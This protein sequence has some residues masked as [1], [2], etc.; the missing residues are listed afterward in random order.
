VKKIALKVAIA[1]AI[2]AL[3]MVVL[4]PIWTDPVSAGEDDLGYYYPLRKMVGQE[5]AAGRLPLENP[6]EATGGVL[7]S[8]PQSAVMYPPT[9]LFAFMQPKLAYSLSIFLGFALA[10]GG[11]WLYMRKLGLRLPAA[12]VGTLAFMFCGFLIGHRVHLSVLH[13]AGWL[14]WGLWCIDSLRDK[15]R[16]A[17][18]AMPA[19]ALMALTAGH[20]PTLI[21]VGIIWTAYL[22]LRARPFWRSVGIAA[23]AVA[24]AAVIALPQ[25]YA[26][27]H[28]L[29]QTT[30]ARVGYMMAGE[31]SFLPT[32][33]VMAFFP[34]IYGSRT[35][36]LYPQQWWGPWH[37][38]EMLG[39]VG[40]ATLALA[41]AGASMGRILRR[42]GGEVKESPPIEAGLD[43]PKIVRAWFWVAVGAFVFMLGYYLPTYKLVHMLPVLG[44]MRCPARMVLAVDLALAAMAAAAVHMLLER[45]DDKRLRAAA[46]RWIVVILPVTMFAVAAVSLAGS[47]VLTKHF[48]GMLP[49]AGGSENV[50]NAITPSSPAVAI[51]LV[52]LCLTIGVVGFWWLRRPRRRAWGLAALL[53]VD[54]VMVARFVDIPAASHVQQD[55]DSSPAAAWLAQHDPPTFDEQGRPSYRVWGLSSDYCNRP[56]ELMLAKTCN[57][58][59]FATISNYGPFQNPLHQR[60]FG[61]RIFGYGSDRERLLRENYL[62]TL[63]DVKYV[64][65]AVNE[66]AQP[67]RGRELRREVP[68]ALWQMRLPGEHATGDAPPA[69]KRD[70][71]REDPD[72][73]PPMLLQSRLP[74]RAAV[75]ALPKLTRGGV[76]LEA[77]SSA[78]A[79][80][81]LYLRAAG[82]EHLVV[83]AETITPQ[84]RR[85]EVPVPETVDLSEI[86][87]RS[88]TPI[89]VRLLAETLHRPRPVVL[90]GGAL[91]GE[92]VY[93]PVA[94]LGALK[95]G[96]EDVV[97]YR[98][99]LFGLKPEYLKQGVPVAGG[100]P[101]SADSEARGMGPANGEPAPGA[102]MTQAEM[103]EIWKFEPHR[104]LE[105]RLPV[106][107]ISFK[108]APHVGLLLKAV[109]VPAALLYAA[110]V[111]LAAVLKIR[112]G[113]AAGARTIGCG[114]ANKQKRMEQSCTS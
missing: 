91:A 16:R 50:L 46:R 98:N 49:Y 62:L 93:E 7:M 25:L 107:D 42:Q 37:L 1:T 34:F 81:G 26:T 33:S 72:A 114:N 78:G 74:W 71:D 59:G 39:Y 2:I 85:F 63:Y 17:A 24:I 8:D 64:I 29:A 44:V 28:L 35:P 79:S 56:S 76:V 3:P 88:E 15:P 52:M 53:L 86:V 92:H 65:V 82:A 68:P 14:P 95:A 100:A 102:T 83:P 101:A 40:L 105:L 5:L 22:L 9:W 58:Q 106:P 60:L 75:M 6:L 113:R 80:D 47:W 57:A 89:E 21:H 13:T 104:A 43:V 103:V 19:V 66:A 41:G 90:A 55:P 51:P 77:R 38:C 69:A 97:I 99:R 61:F 27:Q 36:N 20:W 54:L 32:A 12:A 18:L 110:A 94:T 112:R 4:Q 70:R 48:P 31:N 73:D 45:R 87:T 111:G 23:G 108:V 84:W 11:M 96:D 67:T 30:R 109:T 10:G